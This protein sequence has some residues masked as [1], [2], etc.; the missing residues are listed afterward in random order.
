[1]E[2]VPRTTNIDW[3]DPIVLK[4][5]LCELGVGRLD[6]QFKKIRVDLNLAIRINLIV[7]SQ[8]RIHDCYKH[9]KGILIGSLEEKMAS[10]E[11]QASPIANIGDHGSICEDK[12]RQWPL[13][14]SKMLHVTEAPLDISLNERNEVA[15]SLSHKLREQPLHPPRLGVRDN[16]PSFTTNAAR[17]PVEDQLP[18]LL[19]L[20]GLRIGS[21]R[22][23]VHPLLLSNAVRLH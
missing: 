23:Q 19:A 5:P 22:Y 2:N 7:A 15:R 21:R 14:I 4:Q 20:S 18:D 9:P 13:R 1:M 17:H 8:M 3:S 12:R 16:P 10:D 11:R 6:H